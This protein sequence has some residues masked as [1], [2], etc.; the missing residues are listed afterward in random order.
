MKSSIAVRTMLSYTLVLVAC[1]PALLWAQ[2]KPAMSETK[3]YTV[4]NGKVDDATFRGWRAYHSSCHTCHGVDGTGTS[5]APNL[6]ERVK[7]LSARDFTTKVLTSYRIV[8]DSGEAHADDS[9]AVR[10][11]FIDEVLRRERGDLVMPAWEHD[12][13]VQP[14]VLDLYA[15]L[16]ARADGSLGPGQPAR[17]AQ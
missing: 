11:A 14:H 1:A 13:K 7:A 12:S 9:T 10:Q 2:Q 6:V 8:I 16:R 5:V 3:P 4:V 15:Y 17:S